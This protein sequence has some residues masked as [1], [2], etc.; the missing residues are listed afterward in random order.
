MK[1][2]FL[3]IIKAKKFF[4]KFNLFFILIFLNIWDFVISRE[5]FNA[6]VIGIFMFGP[7]AFLWLIGTVR[8]AALTILISIFEFMVMLVFV[9]EGFQ[10][11]GTGDSLKSLFWLPFLLMAGLNCFLGLRVYSEYREKKGGKR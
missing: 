4:F 10:L 7:V 6:M 8:A 1:S 3:K 5:V 11:S 2:N 9:I